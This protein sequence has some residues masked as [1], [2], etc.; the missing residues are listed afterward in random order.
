MAPHVKF[1]GGP[2]A[3]RCIALAEGRSVSRPFNMRRLFPA[4][5]RTSPV[6]WWVLWLASWPMMAGAFV[7]WRI[8][9][10]DSWQ[11]A[12][13]GAV[14]LAGLPGILGPSAVIPVGVDLPATALVLAACWC[15]A[16]GFIPGAVALVALAAFGKETAPVFT[17]LWLWAWWPLALLVVPVGVYLFNRPGPDPLGA[18]FDH[19]AA[20]PILSALA[21]HR[22]RWRDA[23]LMVA[24]WGA[25]LAALVHAPWQLAVVLGVA[26]LQ[27]LVATDSVRLVHHAAGPVMAATAAHVIPI[28]LLPLACVLHVMW[29]RIPERV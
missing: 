19:I 12:T 20:H 18:Q 13:A 9:A 7:G 2:D 1:T 25:C 14:L 4:L 29:W 10:G 24:P 16:A 22:G 27:L 8:A 15:S 26:Y 23:W 5:C 21:A 11:I 28:Q 17:S 3:A 6:R